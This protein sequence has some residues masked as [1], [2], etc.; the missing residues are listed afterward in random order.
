M[1]K[2]NSE[3][4]SDW[5]QDTRARTLELVQGLNEQ[6]LIGPKLDTVNPLRWE[7]GHVAYFHELWARRH[8]DSVPSYLANAD[9]LYDSINIAHR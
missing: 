6:Q 4:L 9:E 5:L 1:A 3:V 2:T 7:I 8:L